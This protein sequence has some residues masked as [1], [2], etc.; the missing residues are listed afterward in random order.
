MEAKHQHSHCNGMSIF[1]WRRVVK[2]GFYILR[3][4]IPTCMCE[5]VCVCVKRCLHRRGYAGRRRP[6]T[7]FGNECVCVCTC[8]ACILYTK[9][10]PELAGLLPSIPSLLA[11]PKNY[12]VFFLEIDIPGPQRSIITESGENIYILPT[13]SL[14]RRP[15]LRVMNAIKD[16]ACL[17]FIWI[18]GVRCR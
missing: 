18:S 12:P 5:Y 11:L 7:F 8:P 17:W 15:F 9:G 4:C 13:P 10:M 16:G 14:Q 6:A 2:V 1:L 3:V